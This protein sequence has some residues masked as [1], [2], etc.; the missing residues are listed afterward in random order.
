[1]NEQLK[2]MTNRKEKFTPGPW[3]EVR[4]GRKD[5]PHQTQ[6]IIFRTSGGWTFTGYWN[7]R[8]KKLYRFTVRDDLSHK[9]DGVQEELRSVV[10]WTEIPPDN[11]GWGVD[12]E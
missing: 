6:D 1:M 11:P 5:M 7:A 3:H 10:A 12:D 4:H 9:V 2:T 8:Y